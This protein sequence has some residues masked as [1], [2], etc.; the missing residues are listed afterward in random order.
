[1]FAL[2]YVY[3]DNSVTFILSLPD[4]PA[5]FY[6]RGKCKAG[7][8]KYLESAGAVLKAYVKW[9]EQRFGANV[10]AV[11]SDISGGGSGNLS[12]ILSSANSSNV[13]GGGNS[14]GGDVSESVYNNDDDTNNSSNKNKNNKSGSSGYGGKYNEIKKLLDVGHSYS[15]LV[16]DKDGK[17]QHLS[18]LLLTKRPIWTEYELGVQMRKPQPVI[19]SRMPDNAVLNRHGI[20]AL[21]PPRPALIIRTFYS[22]FRPNFVDHNATKGQFILWIWSK[23]SSVGKTTLWRDGINAIGQKG[24]LLQTESGGWF[25]SFKMNAGT[26]LIVD[27]YTATDAKQGLGA[28]FLER[29]GCGIPA[30][31]KKR[32]LHTQPYAHRLPVLI[33]SNLHWD[34]IFSQ[35]ICES[36]LARRIITIQAST[37]YPLF[38]LIDILLTSHGKQPLAAPTIFIPDDIRAPDDEL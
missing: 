1:M 5:R 27:G 29:M 24:Q 9:R 8:N 10:S 16:A 12:F 13:F 6:W 36:K 14:S 37:T 18:F 21:P 35:D 34:Q 38:P 7:R 20:F 31:L 15:E 19:K 11:L 3:K 22:W 26:Y 32:N 28:G 25:Q 2:N 23:A 33:T 4:D 30:I 17:Y